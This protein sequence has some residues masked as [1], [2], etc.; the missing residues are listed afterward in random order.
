MFGMPG[1]LYSPY[2]PPLIR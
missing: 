2:L 1:F